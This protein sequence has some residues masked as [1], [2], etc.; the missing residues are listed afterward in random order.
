MNTLSQYMEFATNRELPSG[1]PVPADLPALPVDYI[2]NHLRSPVLQNAP[3]MK[4]GEL[5]PRP[6]IRIMNALG[7]NRNA[8]GFVML[9]S[10]VNSCKVQV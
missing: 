1:N 4:G 5:Q 8:E 6:L 2:R 9:L 3:R 7:S 10:G